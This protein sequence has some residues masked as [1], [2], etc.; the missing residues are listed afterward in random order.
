M[1]RVFQK[2]LRGYFLTAILGCIGLASSA[3]AAVYTQSFSFP[4]GTTSFTDGSILLKTNPHQ[5]TVQN[6]KLKLSSR[7]Q[8]GSGSIKIPPVQDSQFGFSIEFNLEI[9]GSPWG[10]A[11][12]VEIHYG[13]T[14][15]DFLRS[16]LGESVGWIIDTWNNGYS[17]P[18]QGIKCYC[19]NQP[20]YYRKFDPRMGATSITWAVK[21]AWN[22][23]TGMSM[24]VNG[25]PEFENVP[26][27]G[28]KGNDTY[29]F[30]IVGLVGGVQQTAL[31]DDLVIRT[32]TPPKYPL[33]V[34]PSDRGTITGAGEYEPNSTATISA[35]PFPGYLFGNWTGDVKGS[36]NPME[37]VINARKEVAVNFVQDSRDTD[38][39]GLTN[40]EEI[41][42]H[43]TNASQPDSDGDGFNDKFEVSTGYNPT[44]AS[45]TP[46]LLSEI[47]TAV[48]LRFN[49]ALSAT[50]RIERS[51]DLKNWSVIEDKI[52]G[53]GGTITRFYPLGNSAGGYYRIR[54]D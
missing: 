21:F 4:D 2:D 10:A 27:P 36:S 23:A 33:V 53:T 41:I 29:N 47:Q 12:Q 49:A 25:V 20:I 46:D 17:T 31:I 40:Y 52:T 30:W 39:D 38:G 44:V 54:K 3:P 1:I 6:G 48:E 16:P 34:Q 24:W 42:V 28:F 22:P 14:G 32:N 9:I 51:A 19:L 35:L 11:D 43:K 26:A 8:S 15:N 7:D 18:D 5:P 37:V 45:S 50:Y 13:P